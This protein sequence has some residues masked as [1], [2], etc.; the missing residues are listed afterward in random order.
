MEI[1]IAKANG[2]L[3]SIKSEEMVE[4]IIPKQSLE[5]LVTEEGAAKALPVEATER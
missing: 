2:K 1:A 3:P 4:I 5:V